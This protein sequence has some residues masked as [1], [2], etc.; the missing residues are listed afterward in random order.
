MYRISITGNR[1][2]IEMMTDDKDRVEKMDAAAYCEI[3]LKL[4]FGSKA[5]PSFVLSD[6]KPKW[7]KYGK[8]LPT[9]N[10]A[11]KDFIL[12]ATDLYNVYS[13]GRFATWRQLLLDDIVND[14]PIIES[15][16]EGKDNYNRKMK[17]L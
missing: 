11:R 7:Q 12:A 16:I 8:L 10:K 5:I 14:V 4:F 2:I 15:M 1:L 17:I 3:A 6:I 13:L 9:D